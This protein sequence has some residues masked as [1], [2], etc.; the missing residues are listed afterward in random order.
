MNYKRFSNTKINFVPKDWQE[1]RLSE[2]VTYIKGKKPAG[3]IEVHKNDYIPYLSTEYLRNN[4]S[5]KYVKISGEVSMIKEGDLILL[6]DGS[7]AGEF[8]LGKKGVLSSTMVVFILKEKIF[9][10]RFLFYYLKMKENYIKGQ[11]RGTGIPHVD[12]DVLNNLQVFLP[13]LPEQ[14]KIANV[15]SIVDYSIEEVGKS[16]NRTGRL[17]KALM[18]E[19]LTKGIGHKE[20][21]ETEIGEIPKEWIVADMENITDINKELK[22]PRKE[23]S[24]KKFSYI[25]IDSVENETGRIKNSRE[26]IGREAPSRARRQVRYND[27]IMSTVRPYLK[28]FAIIP[29]LYDSQICSTGFAVLRCRD[30][31]LPEFLLYTL[32]S[33]LLVYQFNK[34]MVGAQYPALNTSQVKKLRVPFPPLPEQKKISEILSDTDERIQLLKEKRDKLERVKKG[35]M[36]DLLTGRRRV[37]MEA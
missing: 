25:D 7:N 29:K 33:K 2:V 16:I 4:R 11:T 18:Q 21:K 14:K 13:P 31:I 3:M 24:D 30:K 22:D 26:I 36:N 5:T 10:K 32:F 9:F 34:G 15:L 12:I 27:V 35:L 23:L 28:A 17:K 20:F 1:V 8:F 19:L 6:W 37:K